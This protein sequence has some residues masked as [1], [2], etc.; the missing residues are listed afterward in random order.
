MAEMRAL[1][2]SLNTDQ[3]SRIGFTRALEQYI[4]RLRKTGFYTINFI[5]ND[6]EFRLQAN[7]EIILL[8]MC[9]EVLNNIVKH[10]DAKNITI[11]VLHHGRMYSV[12]ITDDGNGFDPEMIITNPQKQDST[13]LRNLRNR[14]LIIDADLSVNSTPGTGTT[15]IISVQL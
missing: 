14:A 7:K 3:I 4:D 8:R 11:R 6:D 5:N 15:I 12:E 2:N 9:Q 10:A 13:G 1:S